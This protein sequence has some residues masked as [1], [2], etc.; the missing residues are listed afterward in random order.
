MAPKAEEMA[1]LLKIVSGI[2][3]QKAPGD[4]VPVLS[5]GNGT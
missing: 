4:D 3:L 5:K 2:G 1:V